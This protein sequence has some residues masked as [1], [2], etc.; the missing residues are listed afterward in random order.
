MELKAK[1]FAKKEDKLFKKKERLLIESNFKQWGLSAEELQKCVPKQGNVDKSLAL[2]MML[3]KVK[4]PFNRTRKHANSKKAAS[5]TAMASTSC[6]RR[7]D[8][9]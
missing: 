3:P 6:W 4:E 8:A 2:K 9:S 7:H 1:E 5:S